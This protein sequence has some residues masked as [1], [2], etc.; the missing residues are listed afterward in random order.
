MRTTIL[1]VLPVGL[2]A[3]A[4]SASSAS[5]SGSNPKQLDDETVEGS[6]TSGDGKK[7]GGTTA[8]S[9]G[10]FG[11][12]SDACGT[13]VKNRC[14]AV[15]SACLA[16][17]ECAALNAC[18]DRCSSGDSTCVQACAKAHPTGVDPLVAVI[19]CAKS[20]GSE[21]CSTSCAT[22]QKKGIGDRC[23]ADSDCLSGDCASGWCTTACSTN[24]DCKGTPQINNEF[25]KLNYCLATSSGPKYCF[26]GCS[27]NSDCAKYGNGSTCQSAGN[28][29]YVC[30]R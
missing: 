17:A 29:V 20:A 13:C 14:C 6:D 18:V 30:S 3:L 9:C 28:G 24:Y 12:T 10:D 23:S 2:F 22:T 19:D 15:A 25:G 8:K 27:S 5:P 21:S 1:A 7:D 11:F 4:C 16:N 26:P